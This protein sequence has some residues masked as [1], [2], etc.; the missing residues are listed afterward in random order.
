MIKKTFCLLCF[1]ALAVVGLAQPKFSGFSIPQEAPVYGLYEITFNLGDYPNPY[2]PEVIDVYAVFHSPEG[3]TFRVNGFYYEAYRFME[4]DGIEVASRYGDDDGWKI[5]FTPD[6]VGRWTYEIHAKDRSGTAQLTKYKGKTL[7][8]DCTASD[9]EGFVS[10][11]NSSYLKRASW[12]GGK[13]QYHAF[14]PVG[15]NIA[16]YT[17][18]DYLRFKKPYG[19]YEYQ[20]YMDLLTGNANFMRIWLNRYQYLSLYGPE[21]AIRENGKPVMY[22][23]SELNQKDA[24][25][26]DCIVN[27]ASDHAITLM[28]C[29]FTPA[30]FRD[31]SE[32]LDESVQY[33]SMPSG[34]RNNPYHTVLGLERPL[35]FFSDPEA[36][37]ITQNLVRY[38][39]AR[40]GYATN[41]LCW[42]LWNEVDNVFKGSSLDGK[43]KQAIID[44]H[45]KMAKHFSEQDPYHHLLTTSTATVKGME[46]F[47]RKIFQDLDLIQR[48]YYQNIQKAKSS[49][50]VSQ[51]L[52]EITGNMRDTYPSKP[53]FI[54]EFGFGSNP[55][56]IVVNNMDPR[57][58][59][60]HNS[61]WSSLFAGSAGPAC[62]WRWPYLEE[63][64]LFPYFQPVLSFSKTLPLLSDSFIAKTT[65]E[66]QGP[67]MVFP[68]GL[69]TY[70][71]M[72]VAED[73]LLGW[74]QDEAFTYQALR[75]LTDEVGANGH[76]VDRAIL[77]RDGYVYTLNPSKRPAPSAKRNEIV[78][79][80][81][82]QRRGT[83]YTVRW[84]DSETGEELTSEATT[85]TVKNSFRKKRHLSI[86]FPT[87]VRDVKN[88]RVNNNFGDA[89]FLIYKTGD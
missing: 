6:A 55:Q 50:Q 36:I 15:P 30:D 83:R 33:K 49:E 52:F 26:L 45:A 87:S 18:A 14:F 40:W 88:G 65:G 22:F 84:F 47:E 46:D 70:Y 66:A 7:A 79:P 61:L 80:V 82:N 48:H 5:R 81:K 64:G 76:F 89:V 19:I 62:F 10:K 85:V 32:A 35:D 21:H 67:V 74:S 73:T 2:D 72:N 60:L 77:D 44:W 63:K 12:K 51:R 20:H 38:I 41:I 57:G 68:N 23:D 54:G 29:I 11:A 3:T 69:E 17:T 31:D 37:R 53:V 24:A 34:W 59:D 9:A 27:Y 25:E 86:Q 16:W 39:V 75:R 28:A 13:R 4:K 43:D 71:L 56:R 78:I 42:E 58:V 1:V 8:F